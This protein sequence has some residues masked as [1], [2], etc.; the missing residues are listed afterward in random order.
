LKAIQTHCIQETRIFYANLGKDTESGDPEKGFG[1]YSG[2][3]FIIGRPLGLGKSKM[4]FQA[5]KM[6]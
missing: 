6:K 1:Q 2:S 3:H 4:E 5:Q